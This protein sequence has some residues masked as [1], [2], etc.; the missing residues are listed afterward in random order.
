MDSGAH[1]FRSDLQVHSPRDPQWTGSRPSSEDERKRYAA[2][3]VKACRDKSLDAVAITDHHDIVYFPYIKEAAQGN[4][5]VFPGLELTL[6][7]PCQALLILDADFPVS[8][9]GQVLT[10]LGIPH[11]D[12]AAQVHDQTQ[13]IPGSTSITKVIELLDRQDFLRGRYILIPNVTENGHKTLL[14]SGFSEQYRSAPCVAGYLDGPIPP[15]DRARGWRAIVEG[16]DANYGS[17]RIGLFQTSDSR[18]ADF[19]SLGVHSTWIKWAEPTAEALRQACLASETRISQTPPELPRVVIRRLAVSNCKFLGPFDVLFNAQYNALIGGRGTGK[20][21]VLEYLRWGLCDQPP[22]VTGEGDLPNFQT[23]RDQLIKRTLVPHQGV[24]TVEF[25]LNGVPHAVRR[26]SE[27]HE[28]RLR[29]GDGEYTPCS[30]QDVRELLPVQAYSQK[31]LSVVGVHTDELLRLIRSPIDGALLEIAREEDDLYKRLRTAADARHTFGQT[32]RDL[33]RLETELG[34]SRAQLQKLREVLKGVSEADQAALDANAAFE[35]E[36]QR[37]AM[38]ERQLRVMREASDRLVK[39]LAQGAREAAPQ[40]GNPAPA[41]G[42]VADIEAKFELLRRGAIRSA[43]QISSDLSASESATALAEAIAGWKT[44][45]EQ[46]KVSY[47]QA[48]ERASS[49]SAALKSINDLEERT[50]QLAERYSERQLSLETLGNPQAE[51]EG[52]VDEWI[53]LTSRRADLLEIECRKLTELS[54]GRIRAGILR[55]AD[56]SAIVERLS[57]LVAGTRIRRDKLESLGQHLCSAPSPAREWCEVADELGV[58][59]PPPGQQFTEAELPATPKLTAI[60]FTAQELARLSAKMSLS[61]WIGALLSGVRDVPKFEYKQS[62]GDFIDFSNASAGQQATALLKVLLNQDG[63]PLIIDQPEDDL[64]NEVIL[65]IVSAIWKAK[66]KRQVIVSSHNAN[67]VVNGD[68][69]LVVVFGYRQAADH[70][71]GK[72]TEVGAIDVQRIRNAITS[73]MEGGERAF[74][75]RQEKYGF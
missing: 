59:I 9:L 55:G 63:P 2:D 18:N 72:I 16:N 36:G 31:Q 39:D 70:S 60:G 61:D 37:V 27:P 4:P 7:V 23:R 13:A 75:L 74:R 53:L 73:I 50:R 42:S 26:K 52:A 57:T 56:T 62:D 12:A 44:T 69:D 25:E 38:V 30:E 19:A 45:Y 34:S 10:A 20:S 43:T 5:V 35:A 3:F 66:S 1:F 71:L 22:D 33:R 6:A 15:A 21:T 28:L 29:I 32:Q 24:V 65:E 49:Q 11:S 41:Q 67:V 47:E 46:H 58:L 54:E 17:R 48:K 68:A 8:L 14:R 40:A 64:D 51:F